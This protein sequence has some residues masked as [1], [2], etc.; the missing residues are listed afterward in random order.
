MTSLTDELDIAGTTFNVLPE[1]GL[2]HADERTLIVADLHLEKGSAFAQRGRG[3][4]PPY[5]TAATLAMLGKLMSRLQP[6]RVVALGDSFHDSR[7][8]ERI[9]GEDVATL[10][11]LQV[12]RDWLWIAGNH[13]PEPPSCAQGEWLTEM[14]LSNVTLRHEP[15]VGAADGEIA[16]HLHPVAKIRVRG[17]SVRRRCVAT[18]GR[19]AIL[20][21]F[22]V[23][24]GGLN[25]RDRA[26]GGLFRPGELC[27]W[28][29]GKSSVYRMPAEKL[30]PD[31]SALPP[32]AL[33][34]RK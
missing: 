15:A 26:F 14:R 24:A 18:D 9:R 7:A 20:P 8:G 11:G 13:D 1:G 17:S 28:M 30:V 4:L 31:S 29:L 3:F 23:Y 5:D 10:C 6:K 21:A 33:R 2:W 22:G 25:V 12:G 32:R 34:A 19:R 27:A 16:G